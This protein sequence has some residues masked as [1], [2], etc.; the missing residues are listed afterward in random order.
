QTR[1]SSSAPIRIWVPGC[2]T[3]EETYS[4]AI[5][6]M[7]FLDD[8]RMEVPIQIFGT[9]LSEMAIQ[10]ARAG[11]YKESIDADVSPSRLRRYFHK[12]DGGYQI[13][14]TIRDVCIFSTQNVFND[15]PF[16]RMDLVSCRNVMIYLSQ[17]LQKRVIP[18]F[19]YALNPTGFLMIGSTEGLLGAGLEAVARLAVVDGPVVEREIDRRARRRRRREERQEEARHPRP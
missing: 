16:S 18:I 13:S 8:E 12:S 10:R 15:P 2:S 3:G 5:S 14:K 17:A 9:D 6:L 7:E 19:H 4:H 11:I 1:N